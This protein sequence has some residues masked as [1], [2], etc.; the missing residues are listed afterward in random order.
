MQA[1]TVFFIIFRK[2]IECIFPADI[3]CSNPCLGRLPR[4]KISFFLLPI[5]AVELISTPNIIIFL[6]VPPLGSGKIPFQSNPSYIQN[7][8]T[9]QCHQLWSN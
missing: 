6:S 2:L 7:T 1:Q 8:Y 3:V 9:N 4:I 5:F